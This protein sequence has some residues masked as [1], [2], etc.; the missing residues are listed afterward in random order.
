MWFTLCIMTHRSGFHFCFYGDN[1][2]FVPTLNPLQQ[3][4]LLFSLQDSTL[5]L[6]CQQLL[7]TY[8]G[9][10]SPLSFGNCPASPHGSV[11]D[12]TTHFLWPVGRF[13][14]AALMGS[15]GGKVT[16]LRSIR[17]FWNFVP[18]PGREELT[19]TEIGR[20]KPEVA[21]GHTCTPLATTPKGT[22]RK[23]ILCSRKEPNIPSLR[24][25]HRE[26][27]RD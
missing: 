7:R 14:G 9:N 8:S 27:R 17:L 18:G 22:W 24:N 10:S 26:T 1:F 2:L 19:F 6:N 3:D 13:P 12:H 21:C 16:L 25:G 11:G 5:L 15:W 23:L 20:C 4:T